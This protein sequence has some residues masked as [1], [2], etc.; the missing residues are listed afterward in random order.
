MKLAINYSPQALELLQQNK[1]R[2]DLF[3][4][5]DWPDLISEAVA[6]LP[7]YAHFTIRVGMGEMHRIDWAKIE[8]LLESTSTPY[9]NAHLGP[10]APR[11]GI[12]LRSADPHDADHIA[13]ALIRDVSYITQRFGADRVIV[14]NL[15]WEPLPP[16]EIPALAL[17]P[18]IISQVVRETGTG[19][20]F[21]LAHARISAIWFGRNER[22][23]ITA[24]PLD[25]LREMHV[26]G[27]QK[28][29]FNVWDGHTPMTD[30]DW[31]ILEWAIEEIKAGKWAKPWAL[32]YEYGGVGPGYPERS[33]PEVIAEQ[34]PRL[35]ELARL[36]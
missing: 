33:L 7:V 20:L 3:K 18:A 26:T 5:P 19:F 10:S 34:V 16:W 17:E 27:V 14:E 9:I 15:M 29:E 11:L 4:C 25:R 24:L 13:E 12:D 21:D 22:E 36:I 1:I 35:Y 23:Y 28:I 2:L 8:R 6:H 30:E 32:G 31:G